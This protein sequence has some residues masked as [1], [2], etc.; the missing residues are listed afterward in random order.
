[1]EIIVYDYGVEQSREV[2][3]VVDYQKLSQDIERRPEDYIFLLTPVEY[4]K[5]CEL[6]Q[7]IRAGLQGKPMNIDEEAYTKQ[8]PGVF[9]IASLAPKPGF[10]Q[11]WKIADMTQHALVGDNHIVF[12][13]NRADRDMD[14][15]KQVLKRIADFKAEA[16]GHTES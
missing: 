9:V 1:L 5:Y 4:A 2:V 12:Y 14:R 13:I 16:S 10:V 7:Q 15:A 8:Y 3:A 11:K 6:N